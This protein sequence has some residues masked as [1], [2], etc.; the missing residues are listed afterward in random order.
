MNMKCILLM[1]TKLLNKIAF[2]YIGNI[3]NINSNIAQI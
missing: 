3:Y 2:H 1:P